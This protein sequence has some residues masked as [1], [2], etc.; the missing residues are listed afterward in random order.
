MREVVAAGLLALLAACSQAPAK[1]K[2]K[3]HQFEFRDMTARFTTLADAQKSGALTTCAHDANDGSDTCGLAKTVIAGIDVG[4]GNATFEAGVFDS[5]DV[6]FENYNYEQLRDALTKVYGK[7]CETEAAV[8]KRRDDLGM[9]DRGR[10]TQWCFDNGF[11]ALMEGAR[12]H[13]QDGGVADDAA[14][15][16]EFLSNR[17]TDGEAT[18]NASNL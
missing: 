8:K 10:E 6:P 16:L 4:N 1:E 13:F 5:L 15:E 14:G 9:V 11:L 12:H 3:G 7:P 2:P 18:Y 17:P